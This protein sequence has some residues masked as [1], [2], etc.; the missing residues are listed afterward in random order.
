MSR[1]EPVGGAFARG[2]GAGQ[3]ALARAHAGARLVHP[4]RSLNTPTTL[5]W[6]IQVVRGARRQLVGARS[7]VL[8]GDQEAFKGKPAHVPPPAP[9][10]PSARGVP[11]D[12]L[13]HFWD[14]IGCGVPLTRRFVTRPGRGGPR[15]HTP[16]RTT[17][18]NCRLRPTQGMRRLED[19]PDY[20]R[21]YR[22]DR[23]NSKKGAAGQDGESGGEV[24]RRV[25]R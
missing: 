8:G 23:K 21:K 12:T 16:A 17:H 19:I 24:S 15:L 10:T 6:G 13:D 14:A 25:R 5:R 1:W 22:R 3:P 20:F 2:V 11:A 4:A 18:A 7:A 9:P